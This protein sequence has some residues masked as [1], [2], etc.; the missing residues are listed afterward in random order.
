MNLVRIRWRPRRDPLIARGI[1]IRREHRPLAIRK[2]LSLSDDVLQQLRGSANDSVVVLLGD[3]DLLPWLP[4][5]TYIGKD[6]T[7]TQLWLPTTLEPVLPID[8][9]ESVFRRSYGAQQLVI[10]PWEKKCYPVS[11]MLTVMR[12]NLESLT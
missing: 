7:V 5:V 1:L 2:L 3:T 8:L 12:A 9:V 6:P 10:N 11:G 4:G